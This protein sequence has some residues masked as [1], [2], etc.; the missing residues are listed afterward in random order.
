MLK[1]TGQITSQ[2]AAAGVKKQASCN[3]CHRGSAKPKF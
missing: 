2:L 1:M 3:L